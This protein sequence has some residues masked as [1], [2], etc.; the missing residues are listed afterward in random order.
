V[1]A[2]S[3]AWTVFAQ[4]LGSWVRIPLIMWPEDIC[5]WLQSKTAERKVLENTT[6]KT[7]LGTFLRQK[8]KTVNCITDDYMYSPPPTTVNNDDA[9]QFRTRCAFYA[10]ECPNESFEF[11][12]VLGNLLLHCRYQCRQENEFTIAKDSP[13]CSIAPHWHEDCKGN[14]IVVTVSTK[15]RHLDTWDELFCFLS[16]D[17]CIL[18]I[19]PELHNL[20]LEWSSQSRM[21]RARHVA[22]MGWKMNS[23]RI[24]VE[25]PEE[26]GKE[27]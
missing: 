1:A 15:L 3:K 4:T 17:F 27:H 26:K 16:A 21:K 8:E 23:C 25:N 24:L 14:S 9:S 18:F 10:Q 20:Q 22:R 2:L 13:R 19:Q 12:S 7:V 5:K 11:L 6:S